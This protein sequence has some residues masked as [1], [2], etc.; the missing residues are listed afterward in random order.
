MDANRIITRTK[1]GKDTHFGQLGS[2][3]L[4][5][6]KQVRYDLSYFMI[7]K[8]DENTDANSV[9]CGTCSTSFG[10]V[11]KINAA[12]EWVAEWKKRNGYV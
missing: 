9:T 3:V 8:P 10:D 4:M 7:A 6:G 11:D 5:C 12:D 2:T 1:T